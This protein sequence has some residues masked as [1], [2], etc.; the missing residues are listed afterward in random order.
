MEIV[1]K[2]DYKGLGYKNEV[3]DVAPGYARNFLIPKG[4][5][6]YATESNKKIAAENIRQA[7]HK[8]AKRREEAIGIADKISKMTFIIKV[9]VGMKGTFFGNVNQQVIADAINAQTNYKIDRR[10]I[11]IGHPL[12]KLG[13]HTV[14]VVLFKDVK[15]DVN[16]NIISE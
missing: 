9:K 8:I 2:K 1:L 16:L 15:A 7:Q 13:N 11:K 6:S 4:F 14:S 5:A 10:D 12:K 3:V